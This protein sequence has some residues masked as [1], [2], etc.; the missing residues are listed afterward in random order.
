MLRNKLFPLKKLKLNKN[1]IRNCNSIEYSGLSLMNK[2]N[3]KHISLDSD[4]ISYLNKKNL[5]RLSGYKISSLKK[6]PELSNDKNEK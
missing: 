2:S 1:K 6:I 4:K 3:L 5:S